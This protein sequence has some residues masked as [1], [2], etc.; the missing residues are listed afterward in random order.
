MLI[1]EV[2]NSG[3]DPGGAARSTAYTAPFAFMGGAIRKVLVDASGPAYVDLKS[4]LLRY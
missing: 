1:G 4:K 3:E 2:F